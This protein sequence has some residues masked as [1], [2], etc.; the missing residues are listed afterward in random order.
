MI[1]P[2]SKT[3][4]AVTLESALVAA[5]DALVRDRCFPNRSQAIE[6]AV[7]EQLRR[8]RRT[9]LADACARLDADEERSLAEEGLA[10]DFATWP[11]Y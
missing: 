1:L 3:R 7:A 6:S 4:I 2:M 11:E 8:F 10:T 9:R 5:V